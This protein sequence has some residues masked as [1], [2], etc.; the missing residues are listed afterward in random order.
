MSL[1]KKKERRKKCEKIKK[2]SQESRNGNHREGCHRLMHSVNRLDN[3]LKPGDHEAAGAR[4]TSAHRRREEEGKSG[5]MKE[6][7]S[8]AKPD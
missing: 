4:G 1:E 8:S 6:N 7:Q 2:S 5:K 3:G